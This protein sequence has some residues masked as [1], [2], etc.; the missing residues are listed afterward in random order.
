MGG[1]SRKAVAGHGYSEMQA[2][3]A[4]GRHVTFVL[5]P[6]SYNERAVWDLAIFRWLYLWDFVFLMEA[7]FIH[8]TN[9]Y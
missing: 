8:P 9:I 6:G 5:S 4:S 2:G 7:P 3:S 1:G